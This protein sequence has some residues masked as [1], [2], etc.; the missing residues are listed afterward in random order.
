MPAPEMGTWLLPRLGPYKALVLGGVLASLQQPLKVLPWCG[1]QCQ[2]GPYLSTLCA[3]LAGA[4]VGP[5]QLMY[6]AAALRAG[7]L[8][9]AQSTLLLLSKTLGNVSPMFFSAYFF[10]DREIMTRGYLL[11]TAMLSMTVVVYTLLLPRELPVRSG[12]HDRQSG[13]SDSGRPP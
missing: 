13:A 10:G 7:D 9:Q 5:A 12:G 2:V 1:S 6:L 4:L 11:A 8:A 3:T